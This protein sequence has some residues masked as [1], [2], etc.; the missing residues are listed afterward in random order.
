MKTLLSIA[1]VLVLSAAPALAG[2]GQVSHK[3]L[4][5][6]GLS[7]MQTMSDSQGQQIRGLSVAVAAGG[8]IATIHG[9]GG[10]AT[11]V[12]GYFA[13]GHHSAS[14]NN[15]SFAAAGDVSVHGDHVS[16]SV[17]FVAA[18]GASSAHAH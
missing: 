2:D 6:M 9:E 7:G 3:S 17:D 14:G 12:N 4:A 1:S 15:V 5:K 13:A 10:S 18:G 16:A 8:S 11:S